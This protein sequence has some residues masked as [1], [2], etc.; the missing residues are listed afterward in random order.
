MRPLS[1]DRWRQLTPILDD[2]FELPPNERTAYLDRACADDVELRADADALLAAYLAS[3]DFLEQPIDG[4]LSTLGLGEAERPASEIASVA[5]DEHVGPYRVLHELASGG[6]G[7]V[8]V[9]ERADGQYEQRVALKLVRH[10]M[11]ADSARRRFLFERRILARLSHPNIARLVD[12][13]ILA[14]G[15]PW[16][17]MELVDGVPL[18]RYCDEHGLAIER[19][20]EL[21]LAV[22]DAVRYAHQNLVVHRDLKP[23][24]M[25][26]TPEGRVKLL[27]FGIAKLLEG[28]GT[29]SGDAAEPLTRTELRAMTPEYAAPEQIRGDLVSTATDVYALGAVLYELLTGHRAHRFE[30]RSPAEYE[31][32]VCDTEP[33]RPSA[34]VAPALRRQLSGDLDTIVLHALE[35]EPGR[36]YPSVEALMDDVRR[37]LAALPIRA[38]PGS[39]GYRLRK[40]ARRHRVGLAAGVAL[41][42]TG[43]A[44]VGATVWQARATAQEAAKAEEVKNFVIGL[45][46]V[47]DP[48][49]SRGRDVTAR[50]LLARGVRRVDSALGRQPAVQQEL[51]GVLGRIHRQLG[52]YPEADSLFAR[53]VDVA[54]VAYG[55]SHADVAARLTDRG[56]SLKELGQLVRAESVLQQALT[57]RLRSGDQVALANTMGELANTLTQAGKPE[58]AE[59]L[60]RAVLAIDRSRLGSANME[61]ASDLENLGALLSEYAGKTREADSVYR[62][63][64][65]IRR[66]SLDDGHPLVL[67][68]LGNL[69]DNVSNMGRYAEAESLYRVVL[70]G[71][72]RLYP[73]GNHPDIAYSMHSLANMF[74]ATGRWAEAESI[75]V[76]T[77][78]LRRRVL[79][80]DHPMTMATLNNLAVVRYRMGRLESAEESFREALRLWRTSLGPTH[81]YTRRAMNSLG[82]VLSEQ[83][84]YAEAETLLRDA[85]RANTS[86]ADS[87]TDA[88]LPLRNLGILLRRTRRLPEA[89]SV[90][91]EALRIYRRELP[92]DHPRVAEALTALGQTLTDRGRAPDAEPLLREAI[93]IRAQKLGAQDLRTAE[94]R[95]ALGVT[96]GALGRWAEAESLLTASCKTMAADRWGTRQ[97]RA[98][99]ADLRAMRDSRRRT[100]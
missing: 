13:G 70:D 41:A 3:G 60:Y 65:A 45:F 31:R 30:R 97:A 88:A 93:T 57:I 12:G 1:P 48:A 55:P 79:G 26:V 92:A 95:A 24:N 83:G 23:S 73:D 11:D 72:R 34:V 42:V 40:F 17:A 98:C 32:V 54:R 51:L 44:G 53:A 35:K 14:S 27:D 58:R 84:K 33:Q 68:V 8:Y 7:T 25:L 37:Y 46:E 19:R 100:P 63:A 16:F 43:V 2:A 39:R 81:A 22:C 64:L 10:E 78:A 77:L 9:A 91:R 62:E 38:R 18:T 94:S 67:D 66:R 36:R 28:E 87:T 71:R 74:E 99:D 96:L 52:L 4:Y 82:A 49:E 89:E 90:L 29:S 61:V 56:T 76:E 20:L 59:S 15:R 5:P 69:A 85:I 50:E 80:P 6:M 47:A 86:V 75:D 21:F